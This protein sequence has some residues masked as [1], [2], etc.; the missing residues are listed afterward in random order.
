MTDWKKLPADGTRVR[1]MTYESIEYDREAEEVEGVL[2]TIP[3]PFG[4]P[5]NCWVNGLG[6]DPATVR[7]A[8]E[9]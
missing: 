8:D 2:Y 9:E 6:V 3:S 4:P 1:A 5:P 7:P